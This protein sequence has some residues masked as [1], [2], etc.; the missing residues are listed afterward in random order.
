M[1]A[2]KRE[3]TVEDKRLRHIKEIKEDKEGWKREL[4]YAIE[5]EDA[6]LEKYCRV[7]IKIMDNTLVELEKYEI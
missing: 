3:E 7:M 4:Q 1:I 6:K 5:N 2:G